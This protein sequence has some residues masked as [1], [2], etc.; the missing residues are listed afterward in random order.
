MGLS[1]VRAEL[2]DARAPA[3]VCCV[4]IQRGG[5]LN[6]LLGWVDKNNRERVEI[7]TCKLEGRPFIDIRQFWRTGPEQDW[8]PTRKGVTITLEVVGELIAA[9]EKA[10]DGGK[11]KKRSRH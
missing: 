5:K 2:P 4:W 6:K 8:R 3:E 11:G 10:V 9:L 7:R 1:R